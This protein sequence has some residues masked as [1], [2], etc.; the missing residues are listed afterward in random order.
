V[1]SWHLEGSRAVRHP[2]T[3]PL[4]MRPPALS[5]RTLDSDGPIAPGEP[6]GNE[7]AAARIADRY[8]VI[9]PG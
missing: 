6:T 3:C 8:D 2:A 4:I 7:L 5:N 9:P 1:V